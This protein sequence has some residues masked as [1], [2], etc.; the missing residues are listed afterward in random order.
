MEVLYYKGEFEAGKTSWTNS[1]TSTTLEIDVINGAQTETASIHYRPNGSVQ[2]SGYYNSAPSGVE[3]TKTG[4]MGL[5]RR[6][7]NSKEDL[8]T[9]DSGVMHGEYWVKD[10]K[11]N[12]LKKEITI[13]GEKDW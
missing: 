8:R 7:R 6:A 3:P 5:L 1:F 11:G 13:M 12:W 10:Y 9:Y 2:A 4:S